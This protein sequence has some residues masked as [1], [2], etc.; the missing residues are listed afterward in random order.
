M[1]SRKNAKVVLLKHKHPQILATWNHISTSIEYNILHWCREVLLKDVR[2]LQKFLR[3]IEGGQR[4][5]YVDKHMLT[6]FQQLFGYEHDKLMKRLCN[7]KPFLQLCLDQELTNFVEEYLEMRCDF[8]K[9]LPLAL[10]KTEFSTFFW[11]LFEYATL[12]EIAIIG[13]MSV[14]HDL[15]ESL[16]MPQVKILS[17]F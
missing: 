6:L 9:R 17:K 2:T 12:I 13:F 1:H 5:V 16:T 14:D 7:C 3:Y 11:G 15:G 8:M 10:R 4:N